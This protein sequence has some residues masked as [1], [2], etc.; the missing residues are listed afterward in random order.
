MAILA[1]FAKAI[2]R[3]SGK[4]KADF[5]NKLNK[6]KNKAISLKKKRILGMNLTKPSYNFGLG[7]ISICRL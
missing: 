7:L 1:N 5:R 6:A 4:K 3:L 2:V